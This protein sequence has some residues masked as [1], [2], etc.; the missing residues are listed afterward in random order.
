MP[1]W[2]LARLARGVGPLKSLLEKAVRLRWAPIVDLHAWFDRPVLDDEFA[3]AVDSPVQAVFDVTR[4]HGRI[5]EDGITHIVLSQSAAERWIDCPFDEVSSDL[6]GALDPLFPRMREAERLGS[7]VF[8]H[9]QAT[10]VPEPGAD[11]L[12]PRAVTPIRG[13]YVAGDWTSTGWPSTIEGAIRSGIV[14]AAHAEGRLAS[15]DRDSEE[16]RAARR[17]GPVPRSG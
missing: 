7:V 17:S 11:R 1:P 2:D 6:L 4:L 10:F 14:A 3:V 12:R 5:Q 15:E 13:L 8:R 9:P 16:R